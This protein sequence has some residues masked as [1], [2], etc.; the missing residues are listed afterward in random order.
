ML[1]VIGCLRITEWY[2]SFS[3]LKVLT[4]VFTITELFT[5]KPPL[6]VCNHAA[7]LTEGSYFI[8]AT[9]TYIVLHSVN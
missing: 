7:L 5:I 2:R 3:V 6:H 4:F 8:T 1:R 9:G